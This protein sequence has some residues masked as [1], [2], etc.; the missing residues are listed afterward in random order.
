M[1][2]IVRVVEIEGEVVAISALIVS[3]ALA[4]YI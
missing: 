4:G 3:N 1:E 2:V